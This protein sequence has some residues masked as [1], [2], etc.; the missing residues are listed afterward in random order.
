MKETRVAFC[1]LANAI[2][3]ALLSARSLGNIPMPLLA[4]D[5]VL[6]VDEFFSCGN[7]FASANGGKTSN[8]VKKTIAKTRCFICSTVTQAA[9][10]VKRR[11][12]YTARMTKK[13]ILVLFV[14][15][16]VVLVGA[17]AGYI[18]FP[19]VFKPTAA[20]SSTKIVETPKKIIPSQTLKVYADESGFQFQYPDDIS[21]A[22]SEVTDKTTYASLTLTRS[23]LGGKSEIMVVDTSL[24]S[25]SD[26]LVSE[27]LASSSA[28][29]IETKLG[30]LSAHEIKRDQI[31]EL[32]AIDQG[33]LFNIRTQ[34]GNEAEYWQNVYDHIL[35][36]FVIAP[37]PAASTVGGADASSVNF[38]S[39]EVIE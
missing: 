26:W 9:I 29:I 5:T 4:V 18:V 39:E 36:T 17:G 12:L 27:K 38:E 31:V 7:S 1:R 14:V 8:K 10:A 11:S 34:Y 24:R 16:V 19:Y 37:P 25:F 20:P 28:N 3:I 22:K 6:V 13:K 23:N 21:L 32:V 2:M 35:K 15:V 30:A 33:I